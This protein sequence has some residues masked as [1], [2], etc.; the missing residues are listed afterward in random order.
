MDTAQSTKTLLFQTSFPLI[1]SEIDLTPILINDENG[2][3]WLSNHQKYHADTYGK[4][5]PMT[6]SITSAQLPQRTEYILF[7]E[8]Y[9]KRKRLYRPP[10]A[11]L[12]HLPKGTFYYEILPPM[13]FEDGEWICNLYY[14]RQAQSHNKIFNSYSIHDLNDKPFLNAR[15][16]LLGTLNEED[17]EQKTGD[18]ENEFPI[19]HFLDVAYPVSLRQVHEYNPLSIIVCLS[20]KDKE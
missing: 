9:F 16:V 11:I 14:K 6:F 19:E 12:N 13:K 5:V 2:L 7:P 8:D 17:L 10:R 18:F 20:K 3:K 4:K 15:G 1:D